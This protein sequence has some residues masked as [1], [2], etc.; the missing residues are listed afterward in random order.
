M[1]RISIIIPCHN[2]SKTITQCLSALQASTY[3]DH[4][5]IIVDDHSC[6]DTVAIAARFTD[7]IILLKDNKGS[8][9]ARKTGMANAHTDIVCFIDS[10]IIVKLDTLSLIIKFMQEHPEFDA[11]TGLLSKEHPHQNFFSQ[12]KNLYMNHTF[13]LLPQKVTFLFGSVYALRKKSEHPDQGNLRH[14]PDTE[15]GQ[16]LFLQGKTIAFLKDLEVIHL[17]RYTLFSLIKN[18]FLVP[19]SWAKIFVRFKGW[20][21]LGK[22]HTG[23]AH[24]PQRQLASVITAPLLACSLAARCFI[25][26]ANILSCIL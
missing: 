25:A 5:L 13:N 17:K 11:V 7:Q 12:Y 15:Y 23:F 22:N 16:K 1:P 19:F 10:D 20:Q 24:A 8:G 2:S 9:F 14:T 4:E 3:K 21:Q 26:S 6:D 18:D